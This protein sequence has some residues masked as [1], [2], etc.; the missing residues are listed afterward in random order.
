MV[1]H[2][3][4]SPIPDEPEHLF[5]ILF[6][7]FGV[8]VLYLVEVFCQFLLDCLSFLIC[9]KLLCILESCLLVICAI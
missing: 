7:V 2:S 8:P 6:L 9:C 3:G 5:G 4:I 1:S